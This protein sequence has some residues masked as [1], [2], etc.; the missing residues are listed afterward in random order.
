MTARDIAEGVLL[1]AAQN[2]AARKR[3]AAGRPRDDDELHAWVKAH[4]GI[5]IPRVAVCADHQAPFDAFA[6]AYFARGSMAVWK[7]ARGMGGKSMMLA[8]L[9]V[10]EAAT[11]DAEVNVIGGSAEQAE[12][13]VRY[14]DDMVSGPLFP[15]GRRPGFG[16]RGEHGVT[17]ARIRLPGG[18]SILA[19]AAST[20]AARGPH[21]PRLRCDEADEMS[22]LVLDA[23][24]GQTMQQRGV[25]AQTVLSSTHH[26]PD[27][28]MTEILKRAGDKG[29]PVFSW[30]WRDTMRSD[31]NPDG[32]LDPL[33][34]ERKRGEVTD[35][36][37]AS[38]YDLQE[39]SV[40]GRAINTDAVDAA[41]D[42]A[43]GQWAGDTGEGITVEI[44]GDGHHGTGTD[45]AK[46][47]DWT[48]IATFRV[49]SVSPLRVRCVAWQ[50]MGRMPWPVMI[51]AHS[52]RVATYG[53]A[54]LHDASGVGDVAGD[55]IEGDIPTGGVHLSGRTRLEVFQDYI[56]AIE[57]GRVEYPMIEF[58][59]REHRF[60]TMDDLFR[61]G[62]EFHAPDSFV[63]GALAYRAARIA[64]GSGK[65]SVYDDV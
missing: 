47:R 9:A 58:A 40:E 36:Q 56:L 13:V 2:V 39:P 51:G 63:A 38:E 22:L 16:D 30:C 42:P 50:R 6:Y 18:G 28:T 62:N 44:A 12:R 53:G 49:L 29:W 1:Q 52:A 10:T 46:K 4:L 65:W 25:A 61:S 37:W 3:A 5:T 54:A 33:E 48:V 24:M 34:V 31:A 55:Y 19:L 20:R 15:A 64:A 43:L 17:K 26:Y 23:A 8:A 41:F 60:V 32:W 59:Y 45:W 14:T 57:A 7:A 21:A 27:G 35:A 11:L